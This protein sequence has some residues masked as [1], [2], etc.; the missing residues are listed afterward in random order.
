V[1]VVFAREIT[2]R[3]TSLVKKIDEATVKNAGCKMGSFV[4][5]LSDDTDAMKKQLE[6]LA[7]KEGLKDVALTV[8][9]KGGP[10][11]YNINP[12]ADVTVLLYVGKVVKAN[13][14]YKKGDFQDKD[15]G[16]I[17]ADLP[18]ITEKK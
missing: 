4:V 10:P 9:A 8:Y 3:L 7:K 16:T 6:D 2:P 15:I 14:A 1:A 11:S 17:L 13:F 5:M 12:E 18:R